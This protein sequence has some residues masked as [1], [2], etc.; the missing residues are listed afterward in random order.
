MTNPIAALHAVL[1]ERPHDH[2]IRAELAD[3]YEQTGTREGAIVAVGLRWM[4]RKDRVPDHRGD[5]SYTWWQSLHGSSGKADIH[6]YAGLPEGNWWELHATRAAAELALCE[7]L[8][9]AGVTKIEGE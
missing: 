7:A 9:A 5:G 6:F 8:H 3:L 2:R 1:D 4:I